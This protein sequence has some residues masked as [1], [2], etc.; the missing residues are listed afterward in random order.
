MPSE[1]DSVLKKNTFYI[2]L[3]PKSVNL[4]QDRLCKTFK[5]RD[6]IPPL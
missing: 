1:M 3:V 6:I 4:G 5:H 2:I